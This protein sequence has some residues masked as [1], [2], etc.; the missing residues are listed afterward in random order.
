MR[1][2]LPRHR[3]VELLGQVSFI[4][5]QILLRLLDDLGYHHQIQVVGHGG[6]FS[7]WRSMKNPPFLDIEKFTKFLY[8]K[9]PLQEALKVSFSEAECT[10]CHKSSALAFDSQF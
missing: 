8:A 5:G 6:S 7:F 3:K 1:A 2:S 4:V 9:P 10:G